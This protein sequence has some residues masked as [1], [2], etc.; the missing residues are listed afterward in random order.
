MEIAVKNFVLPSQC[1]A[2]R[3]VFS[4]SGITHPMA[5]AADLCA[6][7]EISAGTILE[8]TADWFDHMKDQISFGN[9]YFD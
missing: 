1:K 4:A 7:R 5:C 2:L 3:I 6:N 9:R 8:D